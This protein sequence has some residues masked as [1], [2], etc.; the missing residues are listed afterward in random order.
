MFYVYILQNK[1]KSLYIGY[2]SNLK[3]RIKD[4]L[5]GKGGRTTKNKID[6]KLIY[7]EA[8]LDKGDATCREIFLKSGSGRRFI[9]KQLRQY[10]NK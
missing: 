3:Q 5:D 6:W 9:N 2:S 4:H 8:Y 10:L 1:D 7:Y